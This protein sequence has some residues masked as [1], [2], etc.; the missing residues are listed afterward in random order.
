MRA[1]TGPE[2]GW[3]AVAGRRLGMEDADETLALALALAL[4]VA[5][6]T[7]ALAPAQAQTGLPKYRVE[8]LRGNV[9]A[10]GA[11]M[12]AAPAPGDRGTSGTPA[13]PAQHAGRPAAAKPLN[14]SSDVLALKRTDPQG[15][16]ACP[17]KALDKLVNQFGR[18][19]VRQ[20]HSAHDQS[21]ASVGSN[22]WPNNEQIGIPAA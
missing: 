4:S 12:K 15:S 18:H 22:P 8:T 6:G 19:L 1:G 13:M 2:V 17:N 3:P 10:S 11:T 20:I 7:L 14:Q 5:L 16:S 21:R 9:K